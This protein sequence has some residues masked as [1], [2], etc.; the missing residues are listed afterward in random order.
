[1]KTCRKCKESKPIES[2]NRASS[3]QDGLDTRCKECNKKR[4]SSWRSVTPGYN[5]EH[6]K[7]FR[8]NNKE[9]HQAHR[10]V[11][12]ALRVGR[13]TRL[14]C[15]V[16]GSSDSEAHHEDYSKKLD[17]MWLCRQH[18]IEHHQNKK[19]LQELPIHEITLSISEVFG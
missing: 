8:E 13:I 1:M 18:H 12:R 15:M 2:F 5:A 16:C 19:R 7:R 4:L 9:K 3:T 14:K 17:V 11:E 10:A 6:V